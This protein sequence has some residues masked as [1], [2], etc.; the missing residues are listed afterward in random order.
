MTRIRIIADIEKAFLQVGLKP[1]ERDVTRFLWLKNIKQLV[2]SSN[3]V[4]CRFIR[5][6]FRITKSPFLIC[7]KIKYHL[8]PNDNWPDHHL[9]EDLYVD[10]LIT[11]AGNMKEAPQLYSKAKKLFLDISI[12]FGTRIP[13][14]IYLKNC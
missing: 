7:A 11:G 4:T 1:K 13:T 14:H 5:V 10:S 3:L 2:L 6:P 9:R 8:S 12:N